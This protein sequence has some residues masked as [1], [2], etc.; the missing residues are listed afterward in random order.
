MNM[1]IYLIPI[2]LFMGGLGLFGFLWSL[3][4]GQYDDLEGASWRILDDEDEK[5][6]RP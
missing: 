4:N 2:A 5:T 3:K 1:L 6:P